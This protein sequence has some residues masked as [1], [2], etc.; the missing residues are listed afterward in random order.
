MPEF[1]A[2]KLSGDLDGMIEKIGREMDAV[3]LEI[4][5]AVT[6]LVAEIQGGREVAKAIRAETM[7]VRGTW[8]KVLGNAST[9]AG[10]SEAEA[11]TVKQAPGEA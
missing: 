7:K 3:R 9:A 6:G 5:G 11:E 10:E 2:S 4:A 8:G 1:G